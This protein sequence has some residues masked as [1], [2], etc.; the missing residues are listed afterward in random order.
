M[1][2]TNYGLIT[3]I[4]LPKIREPTLLPNKQ[5]QPQAFTKESLSHRC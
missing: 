1:A 3:P 2:F 5:F 4:E